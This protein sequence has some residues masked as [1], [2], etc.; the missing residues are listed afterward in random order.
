MLPGIL[1]EEPEAP[2][3]LWEKTSGALALHNHVHLAGG[4][5]GLSQHSIH[6]SDAIVDKATASELKWVNWY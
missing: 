2:P 6:L 5:G 1:G 4:I 3:A